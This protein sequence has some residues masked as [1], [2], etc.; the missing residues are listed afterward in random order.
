[1]HEAQT[2]DDGA[3]QNFNS[4]DSSRSSEGTAN[5]FHSIL[6][7]ENKVTEVLLLRPASE[8]VPNQTA[9]FSEQDV[10]EDI[11]R[12]V[13]VII[14][15]Q[16][17]Q[18]HQF[19]RETNSQS[20]PKDDWV[21]EPNAQQ[22]AIVDTEFQKLLELNEELRSANNKLYEQVEELTTALN[23]SQAALQRQKKRATVAESMFK[24]QT[25]ELNAA[26]AQIQSLFDQLENAVKNSQRQ[27][28]LAES[29]KGQIELN[30]QRLAQLERESALIQTKYDEQTS[31]LS[32]SE[33]ACRELRTRLKRQQRQTLQFK[34]ALEK[35][36]ET[37][38]PGYDTLDDNDSSFLDI[39]ANSKL[40]KLSQTQ[41]TSSTQLIQPWSAPPESYKI[42][43][44]LWEEILTTSAANDSENPI[45]ESSSWEFSANPDIV[46]TEDLVN[47]DAAEQ[48]TTEHQ[49]SLSDSSELEEKL[50]SV[51]QTFFS[52][53]ESG[54]P[55]ASSKEDTETSQAIIPTWKTVLEPSGTNHNNDLVINVDRQNYSTQSEQTVSF[56]SSISDNNTSETQDYW[57]EI[58]HF[59]AFHLS[60][61]TSSIEIINN[62]DYH[63]NSP[64]PLIYPKRPPKGRKSLSSVELPKFPHKS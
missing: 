10:T 46:P 31:L 19:D 53:A 41:T 32:Q 44:D 7:G 25:Q 64:S 22:Q 6:A 13:E 48:E 49:V 28:S 11:D 8:E 17:S 54:L 63:T 27:E 47:Y 35:S 21:A 59:P 61:N 52:Q 20:P 33:N 16:P 4:V 30:Q 60:E 12:V 24:Q 39:T 62:P 51:I 40:N 23:D 14:D 55:K 42:Q 34:A 15:S 3:D 37:S 18:S 36:L 9:D 57:E 5:P 2:P 58:E 26:Q 38:V 45:Q 56:T 43:N 29:Y 50:D 1:M